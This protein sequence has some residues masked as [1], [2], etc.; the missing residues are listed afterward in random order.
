MAINMATKKSGGLKVSFLLPEAQSDWAGQ[1]LVTYFPDGLA[2]LKSRGSLVLLGGW[3]RRSD[4]GT[5]KR[6]KADLKSF[7]ATQLRLRPQ[8][9]RDWVG[10][11]KSRF[12]MQ[13]LGRFTIVPS[14]RRSS[15]KKLGASLPIILLPGQAF[16]TG[17]HNSTRLMLKAVE[18]YAA[19][20]ASV[21]DIGAGSGIL[22]F[23]ALKLGAEK[24][25]CVEIEK[26]ACLELADNARLNGFD[27]KRLS[28]RDGE[29]PACMKGKKMKADLLL[30]N[31]VTPLLCVLMKALVAQ[32]RPGGRLLFSGIHTGAEAG[33][34][35]LAARK[36]GLK[37]DRKE[38]KGDW[39][40]LHALK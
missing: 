29:F 35:A 32:V 21:L 3:L 2:Q 6:L 4:L 12:P 5:V 33:Q 24:A 10:E 19:Q 22:S 37:I 23:G 30:A 27:S 40:C 28:V 16:G 31:L 39:F 26:A 14:W 13:R 15:A 38:S 20:A 18:R 11:Y 36:A 17:L 34:V 7:G 8:K 9:K 25:L 1:A